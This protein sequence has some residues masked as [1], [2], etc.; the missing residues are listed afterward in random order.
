MN[1][2]TVVGNLTSHPELK[3][4]KSGKPFINFSIA[5]NEK[6]K[7]LNGRDVENVSFFRCV[8][9]DKKAEFIARNFFKGDRVLVNGKLRIEKYTPKDGGP[10]REAAKSTVD[11]ITHAQWKKREQPSSDGGN[12]S[13]WD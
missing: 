8:A 6:Y 13:D 12:G 1:S 9:Y 3:E 2:F 11:E 7:D 10:E 5:W 4:G